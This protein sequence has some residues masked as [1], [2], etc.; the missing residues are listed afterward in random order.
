MKKFIRISIWAFF[1]TLFSACTLMLDE[2]ENVGEEV[3]EQ[4]GDGWDSPQTVTDEMGTATYQFAKGTIYLDES[5]RQYI[6]KADCD[7]VSK[8]IDIYMKKSMPKDLIPQ[9]GTTLASNLYDIFDIWVVHKVDFL[10]NVDANTIKISCSSVDPYEV[11]DKIKFDSSFYVVEDSTESR[12]GEKSLK[13][14]P[15]YGSRWSQSI[16]FPLFGLTCA[17]GAPGF[18]VDDGFLSGT[19]LSTFGDYT[20]KPFNAL[21]VFGHTDG[22]IVLS[23][24]SSIRFDVSYDNTNECIFDLHG[25]F[26]NQFMFYTQCTSIKGGIVI[27]LLGTSGDLKFKRAYD[28]WSCQIDRNK[29]PYIITISTPSK[30]ITLG[31]FLITLGIEPNIAACVYGELSA[32]AKNSTVVYKRFVK[33]FGFHFNKDDENDRFFYPEEGKE[34]AIGD[35]EQINISSGYE[36]VKFG[37]QL[38]LSCPVTATLEKLITLSVGPTIE[39]TIEASLPLKKDPMMTYMLDD[40]PL[41]SQGGYDLTLSMPLSITLKGT[42]G[43][44]DWVSADLLTLTLKM[45]TVTP[46]TTDLISSYKVNKISENKEKTT[47]SE[48]FYEASVSH[49]AVGFLH[50]FEDKDILLA[51]Y[52]SNFKLI[53][54][55]EPY[56]DNLDFEFSLPIKYDDKGL[57]SKTSYHALALRKMPFNDEYLASDPFGFTLGG[58]WA[59]LS[60]CSQLDTQDCKPR[61]VDPYDYTD[62][63]EKEYCYAFK[64]TSD[65]NTNYKSTFYVQFDLYLDDGELYWPGEPIEITSWKNDRFNFLGYMYLPIWDYFVKVTMFY[66]DAETGEMFFLAEKNITLKR[67]Y[68]SSEIFNPDDAANMKSWKNKGYVVLDS[69]AE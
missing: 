16:E 51:I 65:R 19:G 58:N 22:T 36:Q 15:A 55:V 43:F 48:V 11:F 63:A 50:L 26:I 3:P 32:S 38:V 60:K 62:D 4:N 69:D 66:E 18:G 29:T 7:T 39:P 46:K 31:P 54:I 67:D 44:G 8:H 2:P 56:N 23:G 45:P 41:Y 37:L 53:K 24:L 17:F 57:V 28:G 25:Y 34:A 27:P 33:E 35:A 21:N 47:S 42:V 1:L 9:R 64:F 40:K 61:N 49:S 14:V 30:N 12:N 5:Y 6:I 13:Y 59:V 10:E 20:I 68:K 52:D